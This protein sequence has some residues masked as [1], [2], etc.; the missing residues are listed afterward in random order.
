MATPYVETQPHLWFE[1]SRLRAKV[2][3]CSSGGVG[4]AAAMLIREGRA[5][6]ALGK[7]LHS[8][9]ALSPRG[10]PSAGAFG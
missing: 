6:T 3:L 10:V 2:A 7:G 9:A 8:E 4:G 1:Q 5:G